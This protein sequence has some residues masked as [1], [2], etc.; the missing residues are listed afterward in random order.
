M[1]LLVPPVTA[2]TCGAVLFAFL[3]GC[4]LL[5]ELQEETEERRDMGRL[6]VQERQV[7]EHQMAAIEKRVQE[8]ADSLRKGQAELS[9]RLDQ[10]ERDLKMLTG[11]FEENARLLSRLEQRVDLQSQRLGEVAVKVEAL[12][13]PGPAPSRIPSDRSV[14]VSPKEAFDLAYTDYLKG[15][16]DLAIGGF[17]NFLRHF[18][19]SALVPSVLYW[20]G[21]SHYSKREFS[22]A[23]ETFERLLTEFPRDE[24]APPSLLK[25]G[26][27][28]QELGDHMRSRSAL[29]KVVE[30]FPFSEEAKLAKERLAQM[31]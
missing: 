16:Y 2:V 28:Y 13:A 17:H 22:K 15:R 18:P 9:L 14:D 24:K 19:S 30:R 29:K 11:K 23:I 26:L 25:T 21:E 1:R 8:R 31:K 4:A 12:E 27:S 6:L 20:M 5:A 7:R 10:I 3:S